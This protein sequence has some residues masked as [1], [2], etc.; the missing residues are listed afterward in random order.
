MTRNNQKPQWASKVDQAIIRRLYATDARGIVD[1]ELIDKAGWALWERCDSILTVTAAHHGQVRCPSCH[2][3]IERQNPWSAGEQ[4]ACGTC[5]W[6]IMWASYHQTYHGKQ[7]FGAN[8]AEIFQSFHQAFPLTQAAKAKMVLIDQ[9]LH[10]FHVNLHE[11]GRPAAANLIAGTLAE[12]IQFL[13]ALT[14]DGTNPSEMS[15]S[16]EQ[17]QRTLAAASWSQPFI[18]RKRASGE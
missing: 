11:I 14:N 16:H 4:I 3:I 18:T 13:D 1:A 7:L 8:A 5:D 9:L 10:A 12:V 17:W 2:A 15:N 6:Q